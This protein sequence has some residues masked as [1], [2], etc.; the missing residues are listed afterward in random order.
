MKYP[1]IADHEYI[2]YA[3]Y[4]T[5]SVTIVSRWEAAAG[6]SG[7]VCEAFKPRNRGTDP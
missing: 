3:L 4:G 7:N 5:V 6:K 1:E 2:T